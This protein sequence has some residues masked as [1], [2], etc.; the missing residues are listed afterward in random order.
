MSATRRPTT[1]DRAR[2][3]RRAPHGSHA[4]R[5]AGRR[6]PTQPPT[7]QPFRV[8]VE[9]LDGVTRLAFHGELDLAVAEQAWAAVE[10]ARGAEVVIDLCALRF[11]DGSG[12]RVLLRAHR[13]LGRRVTMLPG[14]GIVARVLEITGLDREL[15]FALGGDGSACTPLER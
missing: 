6:P 4:G 11:I 13:L 8:T 10:R 2:S 1:L 3:G 15:P 9:Q 14:T 12:L 5:R 7:G